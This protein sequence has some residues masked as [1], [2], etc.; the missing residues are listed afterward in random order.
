MHTSSEFVLVLCSI[1]S[2]SEDSLLTVASSSGSF[3][4]SI[5]SKV[6]LLSFS[7]QKAK[8]HSD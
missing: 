8:A 6:E 2:K 3:V 5:I 4:C 7:E 1:D